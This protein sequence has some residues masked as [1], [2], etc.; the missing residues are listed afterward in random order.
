MSANSIILAFIVAG[1]VVFAFRKNYTKRAFALGA[2]GGLAIDLGL[3]SVFHSLDK[4]FVAAGIL[5]LVGGI[6]WAA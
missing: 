1:V 4:Y 3:L 2:A 6:F 5:A